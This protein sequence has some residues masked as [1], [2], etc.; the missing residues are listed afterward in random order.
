MPIITIDGKGYDSD[1]LSAEALSQ[2]TSLQLTDAEIQR[3]Q[4]QLAIAQTARM[5]Y[6]NALKSALSDSL[7]SNVSEGG[8][9]KI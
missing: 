5:A 3:L 6:A 2:L 7:I 9:I 4:V 1:S 8:S